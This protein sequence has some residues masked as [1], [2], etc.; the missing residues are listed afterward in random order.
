M[1]V[2]ERRRGSS[3]GW[4]D[5][6]TSHAELRKETEQGESGQKRTHN[7]GSIR[8]KRHVR[9]WLARPTDPEHPV[10]NAFGVQ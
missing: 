1:E 8:D 3:I 4:A 10:L 7:D 9:P 5:G 6:A 2:V